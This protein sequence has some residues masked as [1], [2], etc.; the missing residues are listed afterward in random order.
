MEDIKAFMKT[1]E[2]GEN[3][4]KMLNAWFINCRSII[5]FMKKEIKDTKRE[6]RRKNAWRAVEQFLIAF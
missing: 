6:T 1:K 5:A 2:N 3:I 4:Y